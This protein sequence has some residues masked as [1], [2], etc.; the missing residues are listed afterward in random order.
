[1]T[2]SLA[3]SRRFRSLFQLCNTLLQL[4]NFPLSVSD[5]SQ[6][7]ALQGLSHVLTQRFFLWLGFR[8]AERDNRALQADDETRLPP[9]SPSPSPSPYPSSPCR[10]P[11]PSCRPPS[12]PLAHHVFRS[13]LESIQKDSESAFAFLLLAYRCDGWSVAPSPREVEPGGCATT[14]LVEIRTKVNS[15]HFML[16]TR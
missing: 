7:A 8:V 6:V 2:R 14:I 15:R 3:D 11:C 10:P 1:M 12:I 9:S 16:V 5:H 13:W 4:L